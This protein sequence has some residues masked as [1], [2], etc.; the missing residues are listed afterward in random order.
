MK[1]Q[2]IKVTALSKTV[3]KGVECNL[4]KRLVKIWYTKLEE[5]YQ[6]LV[7]GS[8]LP[9]EV[10]DYLLNLNE[11]DYSQQVSWFE[12]T[13]AV[14]TLFDS[15]KQAYHQWNESKEVK[16]KGFH[17]KQTSVVACRVTLPAL[18]RLRAN[19]EGGGGKVEVCDKNVNDSEPPHTNYTEGVVSLGVDS[20]LRSFK[21]STIKQSSEGVFG[22]QGVCSD[23]GLHSD[24][25][26]EVVKDG[27]G[28]NLSSSKP[29]IAEQSS[30]EQLESSSVRVDMFELHWAAGLPPRPAIPN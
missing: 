29:P 8:F 23:S 11:S 1:V 19:L 15:T 4:G 7:E 9:L 16:V 27:I 2:E 21:S 30:E 24:N 13:P 22:S 12:C 14:K 6:T 28:P 18:V 17:A 3:Q 26:N 10:W 25:T 5:Q 20:N